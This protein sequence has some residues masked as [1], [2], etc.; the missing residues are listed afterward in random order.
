MRNIEFFTDG[1]GRD[2][3]ANID[4]NYHVITET[5]HE[6]IELVY[7]IIQSDYTEAFNA[8]K[9]IYNSRKDFKYLIVHRFLKCNFAVHD[10][11]PDIRPDKSFQL[12][13]VS[14]PMRGECQVEGIVCE[15]KLNSDLS[16]REIEIV[17]LIAQGL[18]NEQIANEIFRSPF[19]IINHR[20]NIRRKTGCNNTA[21][22]I[23]WAA[24]KNLI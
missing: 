2:L 3:V 22:L 7:D 6:I 17:K 20:S 18:S 21:S 19:T 10:E 23:N 15:P 11:K 12:E 4:G 24:D 13:F 9:K 16:A 5:D 14:C 1:N 8:L